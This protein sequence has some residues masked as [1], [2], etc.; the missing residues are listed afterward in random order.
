MP[1][2]RQPKVRIC[3]FCG[4][5]FSI[6]RGP[7]AKTCSE[8][9]QRDRN[10]AIE[11]A[12]Y[13][14]VKGTEQWKAVRSNYLQQLKKRLEEDPAFAEIWRAQHKE[15]V[16][17]HRAAAPETE[18]QQKAKRNERG[19]WRSWLMSEPMAW[20]SHK[21]KSRAWYAG[22]SEDDKA[23]IFGVKASQT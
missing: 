2:K 20:E 3:E 22:L 19:R 5:P 10:N 14:R 17:R 15:S 1:R 7:A 9:C 6:E 8:E 13:Q 23:R 18:V 21:F 11:K 16:R 12:R 4:H